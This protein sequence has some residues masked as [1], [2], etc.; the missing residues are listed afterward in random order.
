M[1]VI[2]LHLEGELI[3]VAYASVNIIPSAAS[4]SMFGVSYFR[5]LAVIESAKGR[6]VSCHPI[7]STIKKIILG[8]D[9]TCCALAGRRAPIDIN[10][11][12]TNRGEGR[13]V[14]WK[15]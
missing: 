2:K 14:K 12:V 8:C 6:D 7:S 11:A 13:L 10:E 1:P 5:L 4:L 3:G 9:L 15:R